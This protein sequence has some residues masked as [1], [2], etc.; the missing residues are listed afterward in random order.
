M[1]D[2]YLMGQGNGS[3]SI[4]TSFFSS[5]LIKDLDD[6]SFWMISDK[7]IYGYV[8]SDRRFYLD[9][10]TDSV[11]Y[12]YDSGSFSQY[13]MEHNEK[14]YDLS[15]EEGLMHLRMNEDRIHKE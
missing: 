15:V 6:R 13:L 4:K 10:K 5:S 9:R 14:S 1:G 7:G 8:N 2:Y 3:Y 11:Q 12:F